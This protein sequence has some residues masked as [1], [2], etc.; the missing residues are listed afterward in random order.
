[1]TVN[2]SSWKLGLDGQCHICE[3]EGK[4]VK[5]HCL[6]STKKNPHSAM[7]RSK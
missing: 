5:Q 6:K 4:S 1:M 7:A 3:S 2:Q